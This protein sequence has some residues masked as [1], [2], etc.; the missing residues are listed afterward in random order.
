MRQI[1]DKWIYVLKHMATLE[2]IMFANAKEDSLLADII[3]MLP[4]Q[5]VKNEND[6]ESQSEQITATQ[7]GMYSVWYQGNEEGIKLEKQ[8]E[9]RMVSRKGQIATAKNLLYSI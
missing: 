7:P 8:E 5:G 9:K 1:S 6:E 4:E 3:T 2:R